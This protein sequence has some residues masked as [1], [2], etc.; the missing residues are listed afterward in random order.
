MG[1]LQGK[2]ALVTGAARGIGHGIALALA[3]A[4]AAVALVDYDKEKLDEAFASFAARGYQGVPVVC[5]IRDLDQLRAAVATTVQRLGSLDILVNNAQMFAFGNLLDIE[6]QAA[7][8][9]WRSGPL[10]AWRLMRLAHPHLRPG[11]VVINISSV[12]MY[13]ATKAAIASLTRAAA[14]EWGPDGIRAIVVIPASNSPALEDFKATRTQ[15]YDE[16]L[17]KIPL[18]RFGDP[19]TDIGRA[20]AWACGPDAGYIT[21]ST[22]MLDGGQMLLR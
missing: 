21:G 20:V 15:R 12:G 17:S 7:D 18:G 11:G 13:A 22:L 2:A 8:D 6:E 19:E 10:A 1:A 9:A 5:D 4:G 16:M 14:V 3:A